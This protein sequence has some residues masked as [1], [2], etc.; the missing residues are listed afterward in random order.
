[1]SFRPES[2]VSVSIDEYG[3]LH[4]ASDV[5]GA[6]IH[7]TPEELGI[8]RTVPARDPRPSWWGPSSPATAWT[9]PPKRAE[10]TEAEQ[11]RI[12]RAMGKAPLRTVSGVRV[13][14]PPNAVM[15]A[16]MIEPLAKEIAE[17]IAS[18]GLEGSGE[19]PAVLMASKE[20]ES[21]REEQGM[22]QNKTSAEIRQ[23]VI[24][25]GFAKSAE[26]VARENSISP[27]TVFAIRKEAGLIAGRGKRPQR[28]NGQHEAKAAKLAQSISLAR[29]VEID[30]QRPGTAASLFGALAR[31]DAQPMAVTLQFTQDE[32]GGILG[33]LNETQRAAF[34]SVGLRAV[35][36]AQ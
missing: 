20:V 16:E 26:E 33:R 11:N 6:V 8:P 3:E 15:G 10:R 21:G 28:L 30:A 5:H 2:S 22:P 13:R 31:I 4:F 18:E 1:M 27:S 36:L 29:P 35:L 25:V 23:R 14:M 19:T 32:L 34:L 7:R 12:R 24:E 9:G 17:E